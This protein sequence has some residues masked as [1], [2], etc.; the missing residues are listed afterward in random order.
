M[1]WRRMLSHRR[2]SGSGTVWCRAG[3]SSGTHGNSSCSAVSNNTSEMKTWKVKNVISKSFKSNYFSD[4]SLHDE[5]VD[6]SRLHRFGAVDGLMLG[7][8]VQGAQNRDEYFSQEL[9]NHLFQTPREHHAR[10]SSGVRTENYPHFSYSR[11][12]CWT[13]PGGDQHTKGQRPR[14]AWVQCLEESLWAEED[15]DMGGPHQRYVWGDQL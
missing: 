3:S 10:K 7:M 9:S 5:L 1:G 8:C 13:G 14:P 4:E 12:S 11:I 2:R 15:A 6:P